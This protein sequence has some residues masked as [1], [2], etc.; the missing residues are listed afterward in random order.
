MELVTPNVGTI[1]WMLLFFSIILWIL[2][3]FAWKPILNSLKSR[4]KSIEDALLSAEHAKEEMVK[5]KSD[6]EKILF[7]ARQERDKL[8][9]E[10]RAVKEKII[11]DAQEQAQAEAHKIIENTRQSIENEK[12]SAINDIKTQIAILGIIIAEKV[13]REKLDS[14]K[15]KEL[16]DDLLKDIK[17]S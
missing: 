15:Q 12:K 11:Y 1:F 7:E 3:K 6:N 13:I 4:E 14:N 9:K 16:I 8:M 17:L 10:A 2:K 5:L